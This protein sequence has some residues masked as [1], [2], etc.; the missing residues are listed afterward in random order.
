MFGVGRLERIQDILSGQS[1]TQ[2]LLERTRFKN[3]RIYVIEICLEFNKSM[4]KFNDS[5]S[6]SNTYRINMTIEHIKTVHSLILDS[7]PLIKNDPS[8]STL[9]GQAETLY[10]TPS[11]ID[12]IRDAATKARLEL[13]LIPFI[14]IRSPRPAS[15]RTIQE[16]ARKTGDLE[17]LSRTDAHLMA[18]AYEL[19][20]ERN[21]GNWRLRSIPGQKKINGAPPPSLAARDSGADK[22]KLKS[23]VLEGHSEEGH[24]QETSKLDRSDDS[25]IEIGVQKALSNL[26]LFIE[27][28]QVSP[29][30]TSAISD[31]NRNLA[32]KEHLSKSEDVVIEEEKLSDEEGWITASNLKK[33]QEKDSNTITSPKDS[34]KILQVAL[35]T[36]DY[37]MQNVLLRMN[38]NV[39]S[40]SLQ[41]ISNIRS[42]VLR[43]HACFLV[44]RDM[45]KQFCGR[46]GK[47]TLLR[48]A[49]S[50]D[51]DGNFKIYLKKN[52]Q[53]SSRGNVYSIPKPRAGT[54]NGKL[55]DGGRKG[56]WGRDLILAEDQKEYI[57]SLEME[58]RRKEIDL[59][60]VDFLPG[61]L[62]RDRG[63]NGR[64]LTPGAG[65]NINSRKR[66]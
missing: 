53:W 20:C 44:T 23:A 30:E 18:L 6:E 47:P 15:V 56:E 64:R 12:E 39:L 36:N 13:T 63:K 40:S 51:R 33:H 61:L 3:R 4:N 50:T 58:K 34:G 16:F 29:N 1:D 60:D 49:S 22:T 21:H 43:C 38:L 7:G 65:R 25:S 10:T 37:A 35:I 46:C 48:A 32:A 17:V 19:E 55:V 54:S 59:M 28:S 9:L 45:T 26:N 31:S 14:T 66:K 27:N 62:S 5:A 24:T 2:P 8:V 52:M 57:K 41:K 11:V 42:W